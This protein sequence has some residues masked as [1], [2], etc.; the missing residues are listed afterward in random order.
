MRDRDDSRTIGNPTKPI[1]SR[2]TQKSNHHMTGTKKSNK[3][4]VGETE[5]GEPRNMRKFGH[6]CPKSGKDT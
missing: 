3:P 1:K 2:N 4:Q 6:G 5:S